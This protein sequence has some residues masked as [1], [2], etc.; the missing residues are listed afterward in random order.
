M[1]ILN[2]R[3]VTAY[4]VLRDMLHEVGDD[5]F[6]TVTVI[7]MSVFAAYLQ[8]ERQDPGKY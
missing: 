7:G 8:Q 5:P 4:T 6:G 3:C 1:M 2:K